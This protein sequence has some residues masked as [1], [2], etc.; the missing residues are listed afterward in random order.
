MPRSLLRIDMEFEVAEVISLRRFSAGLDVE[1]CFVL[2]VGKSGKP[3]SPCRIRCS[4]I[5]VKFPDHRLVQ[6]LSLIDG[7]S[8][9]FPNYLEFFWRCVQDV[10]RARNKVAVLKRFKRGGPA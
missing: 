2:L 4:R 9:H 3:Q 6:G 1:I 5:A 7:H 10:V 8:F